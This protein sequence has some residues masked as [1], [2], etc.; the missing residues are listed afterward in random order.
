MRD[1]PELTPAL[2]E[3]EITGDEALWQA[4]LRR[5]AIPGRFYGV[6][7]QG[8]FC[9]FGCPARAPLRR[10][11]RF[12]GSVAEA[13][14]QGF[15]PCRRCDPEGSRAA[16]HAAA[17]QDACAVIEAAETPPS[18]ADLA[19]RAGYARHHFLRLFRDVTGLTPRAY[20][21]AVRSRRLGQALAGGA[22]VAD[23]VAEAGFGS[24]S[25]VYED[26]GR[27]LGMTPGA[28]RRGGAGEEIRTAHA[29]SALGPVLVG[30]TEK[31]VC[32]IG[33]GESEA[34]LHA[35]L[36]ARFPQARIAPADPAAASL[37]AQVLAWIEEPRAALDL[38]LDLR[39][40]AF[41]QRVWAALRAIPMGST[42]DY[43]ALAEEIGLPR[44]ARAV[45]RACAGNPVAMAVPCHRV[46]GRDGALR[47]YRWGLDRKAALLGREGAIR[48]G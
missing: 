16:L 25:R 5:D 20:G 22:R 17:V 18:L 13:V 37:V 31:G 3:G 36:A 41:Q 6:T 42:T 14:G 33:F 35:D 27:V 30:M 11:V 8:V 39:G 19:A 9:R 28:A 15:R 47:G 1:T 48:P 4:L 46:V 2:A 38:P 7:S 32:F 10:H 23:A 44:G 21:E 29:V 26:T 43:A 45:A 12:F 24:E 40:T 34:A